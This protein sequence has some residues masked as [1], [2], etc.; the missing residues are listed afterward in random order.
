M[1]NQSENYQLDSEL[2]L[3]DR[4]QSPL[5]LRAVTVSLIKQDDEVIECRLT[6]QV[7]L[8]LQGATSAP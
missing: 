6:F 8:Q 7:S 2:T 5:T 1:G 4:T 3:H